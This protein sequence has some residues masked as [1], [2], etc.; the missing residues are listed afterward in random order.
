MLRET[1]YTKIRYAR[2]SYIRWVRRAKHLIE[3]LRVSEDM[4]PV[5]STSC[6]F[7]LWLYDEGMRFKSSPEL[8]NYLMDN[9]L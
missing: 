5:D 3:G 7:G 1:T 6:E 9:Q 4:I 2:A 8:V